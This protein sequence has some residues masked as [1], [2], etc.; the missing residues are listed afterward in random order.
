MQW[1]KLMSRG[2]AALCFL[3]ACNLGRTAL[4]DTAIETETAQLG[5]KGESNFSQAYE[6]E[7]AQDGRG[8]GTVTQYE[9][10]ITDRSEIL[11]EPFFYIRNSP[12]GERSVSGLGDLEITPSYMVVKEN[13]WVPAVV[14]AFKVKVPTGEKK[15]EGTGKFDYYPYII[16]GQHYGA[17]IFNANLGVNFAQPVDSSAYD[18]T[19]VWAL[20]AEREILPRLTGYFEGFSAE[21][22]VK[23][24]ST[25]FQYQFTPKFNAFV[26]YSY[27]EE[28]SNVARIG[29]NYGF[30]GAAP[31]HH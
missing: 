22:A 14:A 21:D 3:L 5:S 17:W 12:D 23:T 7:F 2:A 8:E 11:I 26:V 9:Y 4:A 15:V 1:S 30:G 10:A 19:V 13:G 18:T 24:V 16:L 6:W 20:E 28:H 31:T 27:T 25:A 29:F